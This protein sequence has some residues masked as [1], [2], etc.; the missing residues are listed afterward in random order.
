MRTQSDPCPPSAVSHGVGIAGLVGLIGWTLVAWHYGMDGPYAGMAAVIACGIPMVLWSL[1][2]D[3]VH[4]N[5]STGIDWDNAPRP[6]RDTLDI[7]I[8]KITG[9]WATWGGIAVLY[10]LGRWYWDGG[11]RFAMEIFGTAAPFLLAASIPYVLWLDRRLIEPRDASYAFGQWVIGGAAGKADR[12]Q[13]AHHLRAWAV[14]GFFLAFM[15]SVVPSNFANLVQ[16]NPADVLANPIGL[17]NF[18]IV[19]L[20]LIDVAF[21]TVGYMLTMKPLD[22]H[23]RTANP[24][25]AG[26]IAALICYPPFVLMG[27]GGPLDYHHNTADWSHW[28]AGDTPMVVAVQW[29]YGSILVILTGIY[30]WATVA[31]G[32]RFSN[33]THRG[34]VTHGPYR[35]TRHPAYLSKNLFWWL[36]SLPFLVTTHSLVDMVRNTATMAIVSAIYFWRAKTE[37]AHLGTDPAY[38]TYSA[39][40]RR[41]GWIDRLVARIKAPRPAP[42]VQPAE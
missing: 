29:L 15:L 22:A 17:A 25:F 13:V 33:L 18:L 11:Y 21:A 2:V 4:R 28:F 7:S 42:A 6:L 34:I 8:V 31:F 23:I 30:A 20:F 37:E 3:R 38:A 16:W 9:L 26:W 35:W 14:K 1:L 41:N 32:L 10:C 36:S 19:L 40:M 5:A 27:N 24:L 39:W 12:A